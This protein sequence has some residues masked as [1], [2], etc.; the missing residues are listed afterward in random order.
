MAQCGN[1]K[2]GHYKNK[3]KRRKKDFGAFSQDAWLAPENGAGQ[4]QGE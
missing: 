3:H 1:P 2:S 4:I